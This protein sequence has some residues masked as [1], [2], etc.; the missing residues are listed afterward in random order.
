[1]DPESRFALIHQARNEA[2]KAFVHLDTSKR[3]QR[4]LLRNAKPL[5]YT[6]AVGDV[7][8]FRRD[9]TGK[10][11]WS[12]APRIIG[13][14]GNQNEN[15]WV[16]CQNVPV[17]VSAQNLRPAQD[18]EALGHA[19]LQGEAILPESLSKDSSNSRTCVI[20]PERTS[21]RM[22]LLRK[23]PRRDHHMAF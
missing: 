7:V 22:C 4:A 23:K 21:Q 3:V 12:T 19:V 14:E 17:L 10:T 1:M 5:P 20:C 13:F 6:Y 16:L 11:V 18:A 15:V 8:C 2:K 9:K